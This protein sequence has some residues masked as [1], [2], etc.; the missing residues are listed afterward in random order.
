MNTNKTVSVTDFLPEEELVPIPKDDGT[1]SGAFA[2][3]VPFAALQTIVDQ[4]TSDMIAFGCRLLAIACVRA[5]GSQIATE[6][7]WK[8]RTTYRNRDR[9]LSLIRIVGEAN[10]VLSE[11]KQADL[12]NDSS[13]TGDSSSSSS[14]VSDSGAPVESC[15]GG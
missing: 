9:V 8:A 15:A 1:P 11:S 14:C 5:D 6:D 13:A 12:G 3:V 7:E 10:G 4:G 2:K